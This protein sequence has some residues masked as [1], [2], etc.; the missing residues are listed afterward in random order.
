MKKRHLKL[1]LALCLA[2]ML[3]ITGALAADEAGESLFIGDVELVGSADSPVY[4]MTDAS[5]AVTLGGSANSYNI[6][7][8]GTKLTL[9][10]ANIEGR[11][12]FDAE[13][14]E[15]AAG[16][17]REGALEIELIGANSVV[18]PAPEGTDSTGIRVVD[19][20]LDIY[21]SGSLY[22]WGNY[23][24]IANKNGG[25]TISGGTLNIEPGSGGVSCYDCGLTITGGDVT[26]AGDGTFLNPIGDETMAVGFYVQG[27]FNIS[28]GSVTVSAQRGSETTNTSW[29]IYVYG[30]QYNVNV[31]GGS[32]RASVDDDDAAAI[33]SSGGFN[34]S[35]GSVWASNP[36]EDGDG[37]HPRRANISGGTLYA[38]AGFLPI[39]CTNDLVITGG[40]VT[41]DG[42]WSLF[43]YQADIVLSGGTVT[44]NGAERA[45]YA[46]LGRVIVAPLE[47][48]QLSMVAGDDA[49]SAADIKG[50]PF[51][52]ETD[53]TDLVAEYKYLSCTVSPRAASIF[54]GGEELTS[55]D[56]APVYATTDASGTVTPGG[57]EDN[58]NV[59]WDGKTLTLRDA[60]VTGSN[61]YDFEEEGEPNLY[62]AIL[63]LEAYELK[64]VGDSTV[65]G[66]TLSSNEH[67]TGIASL[68]GLTI[69]GEGS[70]TATGN[71]DGIMS[72]YG[73]FTITGGT[74]VAEGGNGGIAAYEAGLTITGGSITAEA[75]D[76][77]TVYNLLTVAGIFVSTDG[78]L[79]ITGG[80]IT[81][82]A[83]GEGEENG[84]IAGIYAACYGDFT[85]TGG[86]ITALGDSVYG[87]GYG[88]R[89]IGNTCISGGTIT[90]TGDFGGISANSDITISGGT[91]NTAIAGDT[92]Y[93]S[94]IDDEEYVF[95]IMAFDDLYISGGTVTAN[96]IYSRLS[97]YFSGGSVASDSRDMAG[98]LYALLG[99][100][101]ISGGTLS[102]V[103]GKYALMA[104][105]GEVNIATAD[106]RELAACAG[107]SAES[108]AALEGSPFLEAA[109]I[110][111]QVEG[112]KYF[113]SSAA[114]PFTDVSG[115]AW[116][117]DAVKYV[118]AN[119]LMDGTGAASFAPGSNMTRAMLWAILAR[120][121]G[122]TV[123]GSGWA[124]DARAWAMETGVSDGEDAN[125]LVTREQFVTMLYR[126]AEYKG[127]DVSVGEDTNILSYEDFDELSEW[128]IPAMQWACGSGVIEG[129]TESTLTPAG[130]TTRA[131]AAT[132]LMRFVEQGE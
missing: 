66:P 128:A 118:Y 44:S 26:A 19:G 38:E 68:G 59:K 45:A 64:L 113:S 90:A 94:I 132:M 48:L 54:V 62:A 83:V 3:L 58:Y 81:A 75:V 117:Y 6:K 80:N 55:T 95:S 50:S 123:T 36:A 106:G 85:I 110:S 129:V 9:R 96:G 42:L 119:G 93:T 11:Y 101:N 127:Q 122:E 99:D 39:Q 61:F 22:V 116:Y 79:T 124:E 43:S 112:Q 67:S 12:I 73:D 28:G 82:T 21:G 27:D 63:G 78:S 5:G 13:L 23:D 31:T 77:N 114:I 115:Y 35:G 72:Q 86:N 53:I 91:I 104:P 47:G 131:Q 46:R 71:Y 69:Y 126:Y 98:S 52:I 17:Y 70:V 107:E 34:M 87:A 37:I 121:D 25:I 76:R 15:S 56:G 102:A 49:D 20:T 130:S 92:L 18:C 74:I 41:T 88:T 103:G 4:A 120:I 14:Y 97:M 105:D 65:T 32:V 2:A 100:I 16:I 84:S 125:G 33:Y 29:G 60:N 109:V 1:L 24:G 57:S 89:S 8:D 10:D 51:R 7:W 30:S 111:G 108:A 40:T